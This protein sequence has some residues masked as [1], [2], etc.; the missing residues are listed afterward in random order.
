MTAVERPGAAVA[1][2]L[3]AVVAGGGV[4]G[5]AA[6]LEL[7][8]AGFAVTLVEAAA[9][10]GG[11]LVTTSWR[12]RPLDLGPDAFIARN[13][14]AAELCRRLGLGDELIAPA[15]SSAAV[16]ARGA[17]RRLPAG[18][19]LG[20]PV[21]LAALAR[22]GVVSAPGIARAGLDLVLPGPDLSGLAERARQGGTDP[23]IAEVVLPRLGREVFANLVDPLLGGINA[24][25]SRALSFAAAAPALAARL[26]GRASLIRSLRPAGAQPRRWAPQRGR[27]GT[28]PPAAGG[29]GAG[30][31]QVPVR[32]ASSQPGPVF[33]GLERGLA[34]LVEALV[35]ACRVAGVEIRLRSPLER[36]RPHG[37]GEDE[38]GYVVELAGG[39]QLEAGAV[40]LALPAGAAASALDA[41]DPRLAAELAA[42]PYAGVA[43]VTAAFDRAA[44]PPLQGSGVLVP[45]TAGRLVTAVTFVS[46]KWPRS[47]DPG[48]L[49]VRASVGR[50]LDESALELDDDRLAE[51][52][53]GEVAAL[54]GLRAPP[55]EI[56]VQRWPASFPQYVSGHLARVERIEQLVARHPG[57]AVT[58]A[59]YRGIGIPACVEDARRVA[60]R[61]AA[62]AAPVG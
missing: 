14:A 11:K 28:R 31:G 5:L 7:A 53:L 50:H 27:S 43:L 12:G 49:V 24:G 35:S 15:A 54:T 36:I 18:L 6:A 58:G 4:S 40:V 3:S 29:A 2:R 57:L 26:G 39:A 46:N 52:A 45:R 22:S 32:A 16:F 21:E 60:A 30:A 37:S 55:R 38:G 59:A 44:G 10:L 19:A 20:I 61:L 51:T 17:L 33:L 23:T 48:E 13:P 9:E 34:S 56:L 25:N 62:S 8:E 47:S 42:I 41:L 1:G